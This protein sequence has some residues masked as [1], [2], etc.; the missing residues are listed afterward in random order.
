MAETFG[1]RVH[2]VLRQGARHAPDEERSALHDQ[3]WTRL[4]PVPGGDARV[5]V[6][7]SLTIFSF[8]FSSAG[9]P[10]HVRV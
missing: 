6:H 1:E 3:G 10:D 5:L 2:L 8:P 9:C 7:F 4:Y